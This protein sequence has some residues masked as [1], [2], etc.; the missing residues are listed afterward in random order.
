MFYIGIKNNEYI[1]FKMKKDIC[2]VGNMQH[3]E[4]PYLKHFNNDVYINTM[5]ILQCMYILLCSTPP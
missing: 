5:H 1:C 3:H 2:T 4:V